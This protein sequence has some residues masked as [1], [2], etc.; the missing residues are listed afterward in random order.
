MRRDGTCVGDMRGKHTRDWNRGVKKEASSRL[1]RATVSG[2]VLFLLFVVVLHITVTF[3]HELHNPVNEETTIRA[4]VWLQ[5]ICINEKN[6]PKDAF[7]SCVKYRDWMSRS[8]AMN[9]LRITLHNEIDVLQSLWVRTTGWLFT[10]DPF[11]VFQ[12]KLVVNSL[13]NSL[14]LAVPFITILG[15]IYIALLFKGPV[16]ELRYW[17]GLRNSSL[18]VPTYDPEGCSSVIH[19]RNRSFTKD[20]TYTSL[21]LEDGRER[22]ADLTN[23]ER[24]TLTQCVMK[25]IQANRN[26]H[27]F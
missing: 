20:D 23:K 7:L 12:I 22:W 26:E 11:Y 5:R 27:H 13:C 14:A 19:T 4:K 15:L 21:V 1:Y 8:T 16:S 25:N 10:W 24:E 3:I 9:S 18:E 17:L 6:L 2:C